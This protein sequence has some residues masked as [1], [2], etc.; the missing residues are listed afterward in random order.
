DLDAQLF[1][2]LSDLATDAGLRGVQRLGDLGQVE[3]AADGLAHGAQLLEI[4]GGLESLSGKRLSMAIRYAHSSIAQLHARKTDIQRLGT[5]RLS[6][7][8]KRR[9]RPTRH[10]ARSRRIHLGRQFDA[11]A[12][13]SATPL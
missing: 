5:A 10:P 8:P 11:A 4:H 7:R 13:D 12:V 3:A 6:G 1:L 9:P 2:E